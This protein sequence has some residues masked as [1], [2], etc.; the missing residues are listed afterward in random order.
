MNFV[1]HLSVYGYTCTAKNAMAA[2]MRKETRALLITCP[3]LDLAKTE[4]YL[5]AMETKKILTGGRANCMYVLYRIKL[6]LCLTLLLTIWIIIK[7]III[8]YNENMAEGG[9]G[10]EKENTRSKSREMKNQKSKF[11]LQT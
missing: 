1:E 5:N 4:K 3:N 2:A 6:L 10:Y 11:T 9:C 8:N 7:T